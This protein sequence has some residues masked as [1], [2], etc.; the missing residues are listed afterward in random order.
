MLVVQGRE[1]HVIGEDYDHVARRLRRREA[2]DRNPERRTTHVVETRLVSKINR[3]GITSVLTADPDL[4][5]RTNAS[6]EFDSHP[7]DLSNAIYV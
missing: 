2:G 4:E 5:I 7:H 1:P 6:P 3:A